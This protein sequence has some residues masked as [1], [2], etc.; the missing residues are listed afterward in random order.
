MVDFRK[1]MSPEQ[2][3]RSDAERAEILRMWS[4]PDRFLA[5]DLLRKV[6]VARNAY[7]V[8]NMDYRGS[9]YE[10]TFAWDV[11]PEVAARLGAAEFLPNERKSEVR[12]CSDKELR[13]WVGLSLKHMGMIR[14]AWLE[15]D[16][17]AN[18]WLMLTHSLPNGNPVAF[19]MDRVC[20]P[21]LES[22]D[23]SAVH[24]REVA[25]HRGFDGVSAWSPMLQDWET[26][27]DLSGLDRDDDA[28]HCSHGMGM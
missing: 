13:D 10:T 6:R 26:S 14:E 7:P 25:R 27:Q 23:W 3:A 4:L 16:D 17:R 15:R 22:R 21:T 2:I 24:V 5:A 8:L 20:P 12:Q 1:F 18:P 11:V 19:A 9:T 28:V